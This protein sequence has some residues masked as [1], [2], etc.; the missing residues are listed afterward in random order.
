MAGCVDQVQFVFFAIERRIAHAHCLSFDRD[1][2]FALQIHLVKR[3]L[4]Q[5]SLGDCASKF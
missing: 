5:F 3:L 2:F 1:A 4:H